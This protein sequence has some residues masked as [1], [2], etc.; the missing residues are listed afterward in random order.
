MCIYYL[1][2]AFLLSNS[3]KEPPLSL[4]SFFLSSRPRKTVRKEGQLEEC[5]CYCYPIGAPLLVHLNRYKYSER[6]NFIQLKF[7]KNIFNKN[8]LLNK[9]EK[10]SIYLG[11]LKGYNIGILPEKVYK[12]YNNIFIRILRFIGGVCLF[13][14]WWGLL[15]L[16]SCG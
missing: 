4:N 5:H 10:N 15:N 12:I 16:N 2:I 11:I 7:M 8:Y 9:I 6:Q 13:L 3:E 1:Y 14:Q